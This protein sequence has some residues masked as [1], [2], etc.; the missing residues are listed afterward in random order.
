MDGWDEKLVPLLGTMTDEELGKLV[1]V[2]QQTIARHRYR[3]GI[4]PFGQ[5]GR[6]RRKWSKYEL[7]R[8]GTAPDA[9][10]ARQLDVSQN[11]VTEKRVSLGIPRAPRPSAFTDSQVK[12][13]GKAPDATLAREWGFHKDSVKRARKRLGI[14]RF[15]PAGGAKPRDLTGRKFGMLLALR[16]GGKEDEWVFLCDCG[17][18]KRAERRNIVEGRTKSCGCL[19]K[20]FYEY[21]KKAGKLWVQA[22]SQ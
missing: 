14:P 4:P 20:K 21:M 1:G 16:P 5:Q 8:L 19:K 3:R 11:A 6:K 12:L 10:V 2:S 22:R 9:E 15:L 7:S 13:M 18:T 17:N